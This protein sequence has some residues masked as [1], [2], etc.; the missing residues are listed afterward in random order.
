MIDISL[1]ESGQGGDITVANN[2]LC[3]T[4]SLFN[5]VYIAFFGGNVANY[6]QDS[7]EFVNGQER[8]EYWQ[9]NLFFPEEE[10]SKMNSRVEVSLANIALTSQGLFDLRVSAEED[11]EFLSKTATVSI[12]VDLVES[13]VVR[14]IVTLNEKQIQSELKFSF[15][16]D[17]TKTELIEKRI[18]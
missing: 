5:Q 7:D 1:Y 13:D 6:D 11:L 14:I 2:D 16:W 17:A 12:S 4:D 8:K 3:T 18:I 10:D 15:V 9:N